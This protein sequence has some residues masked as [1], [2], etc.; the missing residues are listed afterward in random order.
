MGKAPS[1]RRQ[2]AE[3]L[4]AVVRDLDLTNP[5]GGDVGQQKSAKGFPYYTV[6]F[7]YPRYLDG[8]IRVIGEKMIVIHTNRG[9]WDC[10]SE[11]EAAEQLRKIA[12]GDC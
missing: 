11:D 3:N 6:G 9:T 2:I 1:K 10:T 12:K 7:A 5:Y 8:V 4:A